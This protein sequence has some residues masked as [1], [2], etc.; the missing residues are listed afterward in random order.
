MSEAYYLGVRIGGKAVQPT[1]DRAR[2]TKATL[3]R[4][5][6]PSS[7]SILLVSA[8][9]A[10]GPNEPGDPIAQARV[11]ANP[12]PHGAS[13]GIYCSPRSVGKSEDCSVLLYAKKDLSDESL[14]V[15]WFRTSNAIARS[16][17]PVHNA[18][19]VFH[20]VDAGVYRDHGGWIQV[21]WLCPGDRSFPDLGRRTRMASREPGGIQP[22]TYDLAR[23]R[24]CA[25]QPYT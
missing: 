6:L 13:V 23:M 1:E 4:K 10:C 17:E 7:L 9:A 2:V 14:A 16:H 11:F 3:N 24:G 25:L 19:R 5:W 12:V 20:F 18:G 22:L 8:L 15:W 21:G